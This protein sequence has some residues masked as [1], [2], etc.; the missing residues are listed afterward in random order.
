M[1]EQYHIL[2]GDALK[3][4]FPKAIQGEIIVT[5]E[6]LVEGSVKGD[7]LNEL[8]TT[9]A[10][11]LNESY[12]E[13][14][15]QDYHRKV[16]TEFQKVLN[17]PQGAEVN[18]WFEDDLFCQ[19]N[20]W[21]MVH[22]IR[23]F[24]KHNSIFLVRPEKHGPYGFAGLTESMLISIYENRILLTELDQ[25]ADLWKFYQHNDTKKLLE[26]AEELESKYPFILAAVRAHMERIPTEG[27]LGRPGQSLIQ[28]MKDLETEEFGPVFREFS[29]REAIY[30]FG[31]LQVKRLFDE[32]KN[33]R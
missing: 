15:E 8:Y 12:G 17:I 26:I 31:D 25:L 18:L 22:L 6:C 21:F 4:Q 2:N 32:V 27:S 23:L 11:F 29:K 14:S 19:V 10:K 28:I 9:R 33:N 1:K 3:D 13:C 20:F 30:G 16:V 5:R 7:N 24:E